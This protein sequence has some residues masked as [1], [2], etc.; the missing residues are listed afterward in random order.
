MEGIMDSGIQDTSSDLHEVTNELSKRG[1]VPLQFG[2][3]FGIFI[4]RGLDEITS[5]LLNSEIYLSAREVITSVYTSC[6]HTYLHRS[7]NVT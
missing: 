6:M 1:Q 7:E 5:Q 4:I 3:Y 2:S